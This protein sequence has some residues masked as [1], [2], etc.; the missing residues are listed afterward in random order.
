MSTSVPD[1]GDVKTANRDSRLS[2]LR[3]N[4][5]E[6]LRKQMQAE[7]R[8]ICSG[9]TEAFVNCSKASG[10]L[11]VLRCREQSKAMSECEYRSCFC[12]NFDV[13]TFSLHAQA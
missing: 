5:E 7:A 9:V 10:L 12:T 11:V 13:I 3:K 2:Y 8:E 4:N 6:V 1:S